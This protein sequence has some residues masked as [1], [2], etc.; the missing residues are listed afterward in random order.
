MDFGM[1]D[2]AGC[3][4]RRRRP[5][6]TLAEIADGLEV[7][8]TGLSDDTIENV[9]DDLIAMSRELRRMVDE[10][11]KISNVKDDLVAMSHELRR[12]VDEVRK[13]STF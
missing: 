11:R 9:K 7:F 13:I 12:M 8:G 4:I 2:A 3:Y 10:V 6:M 1:R 5:G